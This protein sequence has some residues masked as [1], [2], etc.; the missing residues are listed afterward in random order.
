MSKTVLFICT[1]NTCRSAM[2]EG[3]A[4]KLFSDSEVFFLSAGV[5]AYSGLNANTLAQKVMLEKGIDISHHRAQQVNNK[6]ISTAD[7]VFTM[8][9]D[10][11]SY[12]VSKFPEYKNKTFLL[13]Q[14]LDD[15]ENK[16][17]YDPIGLSIEEYRKCYDELKKCIEITIPKV[18][19]GI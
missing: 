14:F 13:K 11:Y 10:H 9:D 17:I 12:I 2:A 18:L 16:N 1:G 15:S 4:Y 7:Y 19:N 8:T 5:A 6:L 3:L